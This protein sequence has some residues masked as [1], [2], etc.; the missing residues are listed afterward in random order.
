[1]LHRRDAMIRLGQV[2]L[3]SLTLPNLLAAQQLP[4]TIRRASAQSCI[5][6]YLWGG[7][8]QQDTF[9]LKPDAPDGIRSQFSPISTAVPGIQICDQLPQIAK[10]TDKMAII[11][12]YT[13][14]SNTHEVGVYHTNRQGGQL[15]C[16]STQSAQPPRFSDDGQHGLV[17]LP[18]R[19]FANQRHHSPTYWARWCDLHWH[20]CRLPRP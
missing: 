2:A 4:G 8:P 13:H 1:M 7:P 11:R 14:P 3:G 9:D 15:T 10:H 12:S 18:T 19:G 5:L 16:G 6:V 20:L 17:L